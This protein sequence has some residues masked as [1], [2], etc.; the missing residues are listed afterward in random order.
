MCSSGRRET[1]ESIEAKLNLLKP[2]HQA[3]L[4]KIAAAAARGEDLNGS[5]TQ[6]PTSGSVTTQYPE[7]V[8]DD[9]GIFNNTSNALHI[10]ETDPSL[11]DIN[12]LSR[13]YNI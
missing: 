13:M 2:Q 8:T 6:G 1:P 11:E 12:G 7:F 10:P 9:I 4:S 5:V 3:K